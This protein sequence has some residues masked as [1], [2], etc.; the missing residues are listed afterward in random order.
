MV[1]KATAELGYSSSAGVVSCLVLPG[2]H[3]TDVG[4]PGLPGSGGLQQVQAGVDLGPDPLGRD[5]GV[6]RGH[7]GQVEGTAGWVRLPGPERQ[8]TRS[9]SGHGSGAFPCPAAGLGAVTVAA[10]APAEVWIPGPGPGPGEGSGRHLRPWTGSG[11][12]RPGA[13]SCPT[14]P[15][16]SG[17]GAAALPRWRPRPPYLA[18]STEDSRP[19]PAGG[20]Q[21]HR[22]GVQSSLK[23]SSPPP[24]RDSSVPS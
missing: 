11:P 22:L 1:V 12:R 15:A 14:A 24:R 17:G 13:G 20:D 8:T 23:T 3:P 5:L 19:P 4:Q 6:L 18:T 2:V 16:V 21:R 9:L 10:G 7:R